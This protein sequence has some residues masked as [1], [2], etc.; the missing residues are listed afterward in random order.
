MTR[1]LISTCIAFMLFCSFTTINGPKNPKTGPR[2]AEKFMLG[3]EIFRADNTPLNHTDVK[4]E[5][6][7]HTEQRTIFKRDYTEM[8]TNKYSSV[9]YF[10]NMKYGNDLTMLIQAPNYFAKEIKLSY[11][12]GCTQKT[13]FCV[14]GL[15]NPPYEIN[16]EY[17]DRYI[18]PIT[19]DSI[20]VGE[21][22]AIPN[23]YYEYNSADLQPRSFWILD[24]LSRII[25]HNPQLSI[26]LG[27]HADARGQDAYNMDLS[28]RRVNSAK[29]YLTKKLGNEINERMTAVGYGETQLINDCGNSVYCSE[30]LHQKNRRT[31]LKINRQIKEAV[32]LTLE[33]R[34]KLRRE[35]MEVVAVN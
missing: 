8:P 29:A 35:K 25:E 6:Y 1:V 18:F 14:N 3:F 23:I 27:G 12:E 10:E 2:N 28:Q 26:E 13:K 4:I 15:N 7:D 33:Q 17:G 20:I 19:L 34:M 32:N 30:A 9:T 31:T 11:E 5:I 16:G 22:V 21:E 24:S